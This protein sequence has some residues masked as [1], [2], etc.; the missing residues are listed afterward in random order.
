M[1]L[2]SIIAVC[3]ILSAGTVDHADHYSYQLLFQSDASRFTAVDD[4]GDY[5]IQDQNTTCTN[6]GCYIA[7]IGGIT[8]GLLNTAPVLPSDP[9]PVA[10]PGCTATS[11]GYSTS[12]ILCHNGY[13][14]LF[15]YATRDSV[16]TSIYSGTDTTTPLVQAQYS[17]TYMISD[18][19]SL[20]FTLGPN[21]YLGRVLNSTTKS[22]AIAVTPEPSSIVLVSSGMLGFMGLLRGRFV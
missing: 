18:N 5:V 4:F 20:Y 3:A 8:S 14:F 17:A 9:A 11:A 10:G 15:A 1:H 12:Q 2:A 7:V 6:G 19:G 16:H 22:T 13:E 21:D